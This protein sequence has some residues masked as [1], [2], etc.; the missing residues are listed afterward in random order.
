[1]PII[2]IQDIS[3]IL[4]DLEY[5]VMGESLA[6]TPKRYASYLEIF[7]KNTDQDF[8]EFCKENNIKCSTMVSPT[9]DIAVTLDNISIRSMCQHHMLP[10]YGEVSISYTTKGYTLGLS[11]FKRL[12]DFCSNELTTQEELTKKIVHKIQLVL[13]V[14]RLH[15]T[16]ECIHSCMIV[17][18][19][20]DL[21]T[22]TTTE[23]HIEETET[24]ILNI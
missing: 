12:I 1:M 7:R 10:F 16:I 8:T 24:G 21:N 3:N 5:D 18:G 17:R 13:P 9:M 15:V 6:D 2:N 11:K 14:K 23:I 20:K 22:K 19:I 4:T